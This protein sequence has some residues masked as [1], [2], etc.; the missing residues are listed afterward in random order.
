MKQVYKKWE[1]Q[2]RESP[3]DIPGFLCATEFLSFGLGDP[4]MPF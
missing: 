1:T 2:D 3:V 4:S